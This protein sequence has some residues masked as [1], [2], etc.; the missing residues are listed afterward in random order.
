MTNTIRTI[1]LCGVAVALSTGCAKNKRPSNQTMYDEFAQSD[2][3]SEDIESDHYE[4]TKDQG[5]SIDPRTQAIIDGQIREVYVT[6]FERCL[7]KDMDELENRW[8]AGTFT[9]EFHIDTKGKVTESKVLS[10]DVK[11]RKT[12]NSK[13]Q[14]VSEQEGGGAAPREASHFKSCLEKV[15]LEWEF[16]PPPEVAFT[17]TYNGQVGEAW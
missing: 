8:V 12:K 17:H 13:G 9:I 3:Y 2:H 4:E 6:D 11:E 15:L 10:M 5:A 7:E 16:D 1:V 14:L